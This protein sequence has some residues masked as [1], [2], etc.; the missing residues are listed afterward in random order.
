[1]QVKSITGAT[2]Q[3]ETIDL[4]G[5]QLMLRDGPYKGKSVEVIGITGSIVTLLAVR[6]NG[7]VMAVNP[8]WVDGNG[9]A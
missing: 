3:V 8:D 1:V 9:K 5:Q 2:L 4:T 7:R 6:L